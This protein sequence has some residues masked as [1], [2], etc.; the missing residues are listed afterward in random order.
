M[1]MFLGTPPRKVTAMERKLDLANRAEQMSSGNVGN[2]GAT[3]RR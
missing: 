3:Q 2:K 1:E